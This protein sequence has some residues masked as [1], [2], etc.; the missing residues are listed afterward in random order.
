MV[1]G[2]GYSA[3]PQGCKGDI[4][5]VQ[6]YLESGGCDPFGALRAKIYFTDGRVD[7]WSFLIGGSKESVRNYSD[8]VIVNET[9][10]NNPNNPRL[11]PDTQAK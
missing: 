11:F 1:L 4:A 10:R 9:T 3:E 7:S 8:V 2:I 5:S 6:Y